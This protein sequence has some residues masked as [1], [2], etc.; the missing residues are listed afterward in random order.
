MEVYGFHGR[1]LFNWTNFVYENASPVGSEIATDPVEIV[2][3]QDDWINIA[4]SDVKNP[5]VKLVDERGQI[6]PGKTFLSC[7]FLS[8]VS[9]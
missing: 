1:Q 6:Q 5:T 3:D 9:I 7:D 2:L 8:L 4:P